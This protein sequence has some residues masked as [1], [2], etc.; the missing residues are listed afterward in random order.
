[1]TWC[2]CLSNLSPTHV[3][4]YWSYL[5]IEVSLESG[6][7]SV[8]TSVLK[9]WG[10]H[11]EWVIGYFYRRKAIY[12]QIVSHPLWWCMG[13]IPKQVINCYC[14]NWKWSA[15]NAIN[16]DKSY[17]IIEVSLESGY[18]SVHTSVLKIWG[19]HLEWYKQ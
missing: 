16:N 10:C 4:F 6:Y 11:L 18:C 13:F 9:I 14:V 8:H 7:C 19:C 2:H 3:Y 1:M 17:L 12:S 5:I 15:M